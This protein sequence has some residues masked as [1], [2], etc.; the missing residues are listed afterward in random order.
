MLF[1][2]THKILAMVSNLLPC[3]KSWGTRVAWERTS[4]VKRAQGHNKGH[5]SQTGRR[6]CSSD[7]CAAVLWNKRFQNNNVTWH[8]N[9]IKWVLESPC[10]CSSLTHFMS[11]FNLTDFWHSKTEFADFFHAVCYKGVILCS[12]FAHLAEHF[13]TPSSSDKSVKS[14]KWYLS[15]SSLTPHSK[16]F[17]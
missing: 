12:S 9:Y 8:M 13:M 7:T 4:C 2:S 10:E 16:Q 14:E 1:C 6:K 11:S 17:P 5:N 15:Q 3:S